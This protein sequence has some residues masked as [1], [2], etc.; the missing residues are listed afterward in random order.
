M[1][2]EASKVY[3]CNTYMIYEVMVMTIG[4]NIHRKA[5]RQLGP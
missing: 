4:R 1:S 2:I 5:I 3:I